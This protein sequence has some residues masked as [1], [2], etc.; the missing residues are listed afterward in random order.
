MGVSAQN[1]DGIV[2]SQEF[3]RY[4]ARFNSEWDVTPWLSIGENFQVTYRSAVGVFGG[5]GGVEV[6]DDESEVLSAFRMPTIIPVYDEFGSFA[7]TRAAGFN[8]PRNPVRRLKLN[9]G[10][11]KNYNIGGFG[12]I[13]LLLK[14][15]EGLTLRT[16]LGGSYNNYHYVDYNFRY[17]GDSEPEAS[18]FFSEGSGYGF[19]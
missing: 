4:A 7:S 13:Y 12:N 19:A 10:D 17:L 9:N 11:D 14:P 15:I 5:A 1:Q 16:S 18:N 8:N 2:L 3:S 6:A